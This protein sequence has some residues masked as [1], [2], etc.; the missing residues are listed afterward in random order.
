M[1]D[2]SIERVLTIDVDG[3]SV[4][5][6]VLIAGP[7]AQ[8]GGYAQLA[9]DPESGP[10]STAGRIASA[11]DATKDLPVVVTAHDTLEAATD[12]VTAIRAQ[13]FDDVVVTSRTDAIAYANPAGV[14]SPESLAGAAIPDGLLAAHDGLTLG[15]LAGVV[16]AGLERLGVTAEVDTDSPDVDVWS[17][18]AVGAAA[19]ATAVAASAIS[20]DDSSLADEADAFD[21]AEVDASARTD[22]ADAEGEGSV[23]GLGEREAATGA[24]ALSADAADAAAD[25]SISAA[26]SVEASED[27]DGVVAAGLAGVA[28]AGAGHIAASDGQSIDAATVLD[29]LAASDAGEME[30]APVLAAAPPETVQQEAPAAPAERS[31]RRGLL[32]ALLAVAALVIAGLL[33]S[34]CLGSDDDEGAEAPVAIEDEDATAASAAEGAG[35][36]DEADEGSGTIDG[37]DQSSED[38]SQGA[39]GSTEVEPTAEPEPTVA[40]EPTPTAEP[41]PEPTPDPLEGLPPLSELPE[42]GAIFRPPILYLEGPVQTQEESDAIYQRAIEV[43][44]PD[45][46]VRDHIVRPDAPGSTDGNVRVEQAVLFQTGSAVIA[47]QFVPTLELGVLVL[48][49]NPQVTMV[50]EG[51]TDSVGSDESNQ[52][53]S[54]RRAEA[55]VEYM[56]S[57]GVERDRLQA[58]GLGEGSP[59]ASNDDEEGRQINRRIE[60]QLIDLL[61]VE[62]E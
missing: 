45:N 12:V 23:S 34:Q 31:S 59:V 50:V 32:A 52:L 49:L 30:V 38:D 19:A 21:S 51:H 60:V 4:R 53:L 11:L 43:V 3:T 42:R 39:V 46:V 16:G 41:T 58:V 37:A 22:L 27:S 25:A 40:P 28:A 15:Q 8:P 57:R 56:V 5:G 20:D 29:S 14:D 18:S 10:A 44:G 7:P 9:Y 61:V 48:T 62:A 17:P 55:V 26:G 54:E 47:E 24:A 1:V 33:L 13:G 6:M 35:E 2:G 36:A